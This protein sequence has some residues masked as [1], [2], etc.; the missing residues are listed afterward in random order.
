MPA[1]IVTLHD[2]EDMIMY[3]E[4]HVDAVHMPDGKRTLRAEL[5]ELEDDSKTIVFNNDGTITET[6]TNSGMYVITEFPPDGT[7]VETCYYSDETIYWVETTTFNDDGSITVE[8]VYADNTPEP[9]DEQEG[10]G[11]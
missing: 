1:K 2:K 7:V 4:T 11:E 8:K 3:P 5:E 10:A 6:K 9:N